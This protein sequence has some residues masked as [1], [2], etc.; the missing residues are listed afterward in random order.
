MTK[1]QFIKELAM[2]QDNIVCALDGDIT[3]V[4]D[5]LMLFELEG[6]IIHCPFL[7]VDG[8]SI[9]DPVTYY[10]EAYLK[11]GWSKYM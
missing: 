11:S 6:N 10:G 9:V 3:K 2:F 4:E 1:N 8:A 5:C 7:D